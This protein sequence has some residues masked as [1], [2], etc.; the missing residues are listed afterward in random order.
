MGCSGQAL[1]PLIWS[2][3]RRHQLDRTDAEDVGQYV[4]LKVVDQLGNVRDPAALAG[5]RPP[6]RRNAPRLCGRCGACP[7][8]GRCSRPAISPIRRPRQPSRSYCEP[9]GTPHCA[10]RSPVC[11]QAAS[12]CSPCSPQTP[13]ALRPISA[14]LGIPA[15]SIGPAR[16]RCLQKLRR[17]P[18]LAAL[19]DARQTSADT[20]L[21]GQAAPTVTTIS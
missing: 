8:P 1:R 16:S 20:Q 11:R 15:G 10:T 17:H 12:G 9:N 7:P 6:P 3:C 5:W 2:I 14:E 21:P 18:A 4:W 19:I 13:D